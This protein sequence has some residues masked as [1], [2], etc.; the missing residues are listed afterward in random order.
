MRSG[1]KATKQAPSGKGDG[2]RVR[3]FGSKIA[4]QPKREGGD[5]FAVYL[6][7]EADQGDAFS[8]LPVFLE[9]SPGQDREE[10]P[11]ATS[12]PPLRDLS[13]R[14]VSFTGLTPLIQCD[15]PDAY[16]QER[17]GSQGISTDSVQLDHMVSQKTLKS[18]A[19]TYKWL[20]ALTSDPKS[21]WGAVK[22]ELDKLRAA[23]KTIP[24]QGHEF[25]SENHLINIPQ[26]IIPGLQGQIQGAGEEFDPQVAKV[27]RA[28]WRLAQ[29]A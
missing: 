23:V 21:Q 14:R 6:Q 10:P 28:D 4:R 13:P 25:M 7:R 17:R 2:F 27:G 24:S 20:E 26:N 5:L 15:F 29:L 12:Q 19:D 3:P 11:A 22:A 1:I 8:R 9:S 16:N 18:F